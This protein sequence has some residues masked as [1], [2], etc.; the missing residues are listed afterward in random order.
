[1]VPELKSVESISLLN[2]FSHPNLPLRPFVFHGSSGY[3]NK[4]MVSDLVTF[5]LSDK[6]QPCA[7]YTMI[8]QDSYLDTSDSVT[9]KHLTQWLTSSNLSPKVRI[10][11]VI[12]S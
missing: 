5:F 2:Q 8:C 10:E 6:E 3:Q 12:L 9:L 7:L 11:S 1:M 4:N